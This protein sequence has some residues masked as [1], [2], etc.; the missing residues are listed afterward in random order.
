MYNS[1]YRI[2]TYHR[3]GDVITGTHVDPS[4]TLVDYRENN[5][6]FYK[7]N[8]PYFQKPKLMHFEMEDDEGIEYDKYGYPIRK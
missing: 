2:Y 4:F 6:I 8:F 1:L 5:E 7:A 3:F